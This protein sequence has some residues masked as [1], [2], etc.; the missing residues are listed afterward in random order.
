MVDFLKNNKVLPGY[1][2]AIEIPVQW[3]EVDAYGHVNNTV[4]FRYFESARMAYL[5]SCGVLESYK[6]DRVGI[7]LHSTECRFRSALH[8]PDSVLVGARTIQIESDRFVM[9]YSAVSLTHE[10]IAAEGRAILV[11]FDYNSRTKVPLPD[12]VRTSIEQLEQNS[13][14]T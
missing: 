9:A 6:R 2:V 1:P 13:K 14:S 4:F 3:G 10:L 5:E 7:I 8:H 12:S 11:W